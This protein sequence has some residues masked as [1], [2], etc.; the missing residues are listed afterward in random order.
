MQA[1]TQPSEAPLL[2]LVNGRPATG[3]TSIAER[4]STD[5]GIP[6]FT[7]DAVK[8]LLGEVVGAADRDAART[9]GE[10]SIA[11]IFQHAEAVLAS[12]AAVIVECPLI[13]ELSERPLR[14]LQE[15]TRCRIMQI[16]LVAHADVILSRY[17]ARDR[18]EVHF[19]DEARK[20]LEVSLRLTQVDP[21]PVTGETV[22]IDTTDFDSV[23]V[24]ALVERVRAA[25]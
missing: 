15:R 21:V 19:D 24:D 23:D 17:D 20:E 3:K 1:M 22:H 12:G 6:L 9:L 14:E 5:L 25:L 4:L 2:V 7:K 13:P 8:E 18:N 11:L 10:A 16:F